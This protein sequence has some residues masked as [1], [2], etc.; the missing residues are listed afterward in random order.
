M[1]FSAAGIMIMLLQQNVIEAD[2]QDVKGWGV[3]LTR[4]RHGSCYKILF[5]LMY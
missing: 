1:R 2:N 3:N 4:N 5:S